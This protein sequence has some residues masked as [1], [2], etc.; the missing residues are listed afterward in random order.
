[1][2]PPTDVIVGFVECIPEPET[3]LDDIVESVFGETLVYIRLQM[4]DSNG[5]YNIPRNGLP[6]GIRGGDTF[7]VEDGKTRFP[8]KEE[9][10]RWWPS[11]ATPTN[12]LSPEEINDLDADWW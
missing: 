9:T 12:Y 7:I 1:M 6:D 2:P 4:G 10:E 11:P 3:V 8:T 5:H